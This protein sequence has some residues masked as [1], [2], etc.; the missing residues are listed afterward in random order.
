MY[1]EKFTSVCPSFCL[2][3]ALDRENFVISNL[4]SCWVISI[5]EY[6]VCDP[7]FSLSARAQLQS[8]AFLVFARKDKIFAMAGREQELVELTSKIK[9]EV[10]DL[11]TIED[12]FIIDARKA[13]SDQMKSLKELVSQTSETVRKARIDRKVSKDLFIV[14]KTCRVSVVIMELSLQ[15]CTLEKLK[16]KKH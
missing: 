7:L 11:L 14:S 8:K 12:H 6:N 9:Q 13:S 2:P 1:R 16:C 3:M 15:Q 5:T 10:K 4:Q